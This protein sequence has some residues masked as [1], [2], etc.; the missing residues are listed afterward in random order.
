MGFSNLW[1]IEWFGLRH[2]IPFLLKLGCCAQRHAGIIEPAGK[3][4][5]GSQHSSNVVSAITFGGRGIGGG[6]MGLMELSPCKHGAGGRA[7][8]KPECRLWVTAGAGRSR[9][10]DTRSSVLL[11]SMSGKSQPVKVRGGRGWGERGSEA[12]CGTIGASYWS[13]SSTGGV[14]AAAC[15]LEEA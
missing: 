7:A 3:Q 1:A 10:S 13:V 6:R 4:V 14:P 12:G 2:I 15:N 9:N 11:P 8:G 5:R